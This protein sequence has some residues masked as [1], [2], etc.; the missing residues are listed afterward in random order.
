MPLIVRQWTSPQ[1]KLRRRE[2]WGYSLSK[3]VWNVGNTDSLWR[4]RGW[5]QLTRET[6]ESSGEILSHYLSLQFPLLFRSVL[7]SFSSLFKCLTASTLQFWF[8]LNPLKGEFSVKK[9]P[10]SQK[11]M[12]PC[13]CWYRSAQLNSTLSEEWCFVFWFFIAFRRAYIRA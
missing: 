12:K 9:A 2:T 10:T 13:F 11:H 4:K 1:Q 3:S 6:M 7:S 5:S 8:S